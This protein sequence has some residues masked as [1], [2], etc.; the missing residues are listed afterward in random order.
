MWTYQPPLQDFEFV[1][2]K[3]LDAGAAWKAMPA[4]AGL[5]IETAQQILEEA[6]RFASEVLAPINSAGDLE[7]CRLQDGN[8]ATPA[9]YKEAYRAYVEAGWPSLGCREED[10]GQG[11][12]HSLHAALYEMLNTACHAW[13]M[14]P[15]LASGAY[16]CLRVHGS[17]SLKA[18]YLPKLVSGEW[19]ATMCLTESHA[20]SDV[21]LLRTRAE[22]DGEQRYRITGNK[23][24]I[25]GGEHDLTPNIVHLVLARLP[26]APPGTKGISLFLV[27]KMIADEHGLRPN[28]VRCD[29]I[30]KKMGIKGSATCVLNFDH[31]V[32]W[33]IGEPHRG[34]AAMF[35]MMNAARLHVGLQGLAHAEAASQIALAYAAERVQMRAPLRSG[36]GVADPII[37]H[38]AIRR[39]LWQLRAFT[40][41]QRC[42]ALWAAHLLDLAEHH[43]DAE[44]RGKALQL[45]SLL[46]P[47]VKAFMTENGFA[48]TNAGLQVLGGHGY[49]HENAI[50]QSVRDARIAPIYEGTNEIQ[51]IDLLV[52]KVVAD[53]GATLQ[54]LL[55]ILGAEADACVAVPSTRSFG[56]ALRE[57]LAALTEETDKLCA[58]SQ[59]DIELPYRAADDYLRWLGLVLLAYA[60][61]RAARLVEDM[62]A[63]LRQRKRLAAQ[64]Y[65]DVLLTEAD[66]RRQLIGKARAGLPAVTR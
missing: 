33:L 28:A 19:L 41:G 61:A 31:A 26:D 58:E 50:E 7:G 46:T 45:A 37:E 52:R 34:L 23:I 13:A 11:L 60:W 56:Q 65:F 57:Q 55:S 59:S 16:E 1:L 32:G 3:W 29:G 63:S 48:L 24:F 15:G 54:Q 9:G 38:P 21:G 64:F 51:A 22:A 49:V 8:V 12:P 5:D 40:E 66:Y 2:S 53:R 47:V 35:V 10:G 17:A 27:P 42:I 43:P 20:G 30:E 4:H 36:H 25:S 18:A 6:G 44:R 14:Y 39:I 62:E